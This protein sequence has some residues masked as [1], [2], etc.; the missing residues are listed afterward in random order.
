MQ[1]QK[2]RARTHTNTHSDQEGAEMRGWRRG[3]GEECFVR[4]PARPHSKNKKTK[5][6]SCGLAIGDWRPSFRAF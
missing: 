2:T 4:S 1:L 6:Y 5:N 3:R